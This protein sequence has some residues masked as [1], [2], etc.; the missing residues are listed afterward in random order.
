MLAVHLDTVRLFLH[1]LAATVWVGGQIT[2]AGLLPTIRLLGP[3]ATRAVARGF[4]RLAW[5][6]FAVLVATGIWNIAAAAPS[7]DTA[8]D[9]T[10]ALKIAVVALSGVAAA[11]HG[12]SSSRRALAVWGALGGL[13]GLG[14][15]FLG[16]LLAG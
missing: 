16:V 1:V 14:A 13:A 9:A 6:A 11:L 5:P 7:G 4:N 15:L 3:E 12:R 2:L 10:L 8:Y